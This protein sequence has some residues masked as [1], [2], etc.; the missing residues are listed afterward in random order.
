[1]TPCETKAK[2]KHPSYGKV[3][4][5]FARNSLV[6][7]MMFRANFLIESVSSVCWAIMNVGLYW[8]IFEHT[9]S[10]GRDTGWGK[11]EF[12]VFMGTTWII[13]SLMQTFFMPN[14]EEFSELIRTGGLDFAMLK[15]IDTQFLISLR[16]VSWSSLSNL[17]FGILLMVISLAHLMTRAENPWHFQPSIVV[18]YPLYIACGVAILYSLMICLAATSVWLG[19]NQTLYDFWFYITNFSRYPMEIYARGW[20]LPLLFVFTFVIPVLV[21]VN[22]PARLLAQPLTPRASWEWPLAGFTLLATVSSLNVSRW[23]FQKA[24][25]SYRSASS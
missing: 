11:Y 2:S 23:V 19:R 18:L 6:R 13:N 24:L 25:R 21:V 9:T 1:M 8:I 17:L 12:F 16:K 10:I 15:P 14:S 4:L 20:G 22:V 7:D 3:F 5:M